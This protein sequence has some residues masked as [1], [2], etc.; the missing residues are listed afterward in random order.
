MPTV[1]TMATTR[2]ALNDVFLNCT[3][4][5]VGPVAFTAFAT[6][7]NA[8]WLHCSAA[9]VLLGVITVRE[10]FV[11]STMRP[12]ENV[13]ST[14]TV[15]DDATP[16]G[17]LESPRVLKRKGPV[18]AIEIG[19]GSA[20]AKLVFPTPITTPLLQPVL[21]CK[22]AR[23]SDDALLVAPAATRANV[24]F[25]ICMLPSSDEY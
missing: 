13:T 21:G 7:H 2:L 17:A 4:T 5:L 18:T 19:V 9:S 16:K 6:S 12:S 8:P 11:R 20:S 23:T 14:D 15:P 3:S 22:A 24:A 25:Q 10:S 1:R